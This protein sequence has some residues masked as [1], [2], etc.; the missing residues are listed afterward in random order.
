MSPDGKDRAEGGG[1]P[2]GRNWEKAGEGRCQ[3][4]WVVAAPVSEEVSP[5]ERDGHL[6]STAPGHPSAQWDV[7]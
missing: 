4:T 7:V 2:G 3:V 5:S 1:G 6:H